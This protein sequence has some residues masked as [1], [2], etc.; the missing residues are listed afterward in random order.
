[1]MGA[2]TILTALESACE[3]KMHICRSA[4]KAYDALLPALEAAR[5]AAEEFDAA[6][7]REGLPAIHMGRLGQ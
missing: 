1:M 7:R 5:I 2:A 3:Q 6:V 4:E